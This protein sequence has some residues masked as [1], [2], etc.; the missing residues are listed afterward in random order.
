MTTASPPDFDHPDLMARLARLDD[1]GL[2]ALPFGVIGFG[3]EFDAKVVRY[4]ARESRESG[5]ERSRVVDLPLFSVVAQCLNNY[6][7]A[8]RFDDAVEAGRPLDATLDFT[9]TLRMKP[10]PVRL[11]LLS[12]PDHATQFIAIRRA[13]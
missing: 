10:T 13:A 8:Q 1:A 9:F 5:L 12:S 11:R 4:S 6:L 2:D 3:K 7:V